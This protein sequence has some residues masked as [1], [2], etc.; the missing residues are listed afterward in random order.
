MN[1]K[2]FTLVELLG[3]LVLLGV[4]LCIGLYSIR[5]TLATSLSSLTEVSK[6]EIY[7]AARTYVMENG[8]T[9][10]NDSEEYTCLEVVTL[11]DYGYFSWNEV[12]FYEGSKI[13]LVRDPISKVITNTSMVDK[14]E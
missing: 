11:V 6:S 3:S 9:W 12:K 5:G 13:K 14:C 1:R 4:V 2:G 10:I 7:D 8:V